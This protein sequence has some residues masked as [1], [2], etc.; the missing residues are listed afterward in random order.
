MSRAF[1][2]ELTSVPDRT[3]VVAEVW[4]QDE[5]LAELRRERGVVRIQLYK[6]PGA[7]WDLAY[8]GFLAA[9]EEARAR[10]G[11]GP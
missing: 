6:S 5:L 11:S 2:V 4:F 7:A 1:K 3:D 10:L 9:V 8:D